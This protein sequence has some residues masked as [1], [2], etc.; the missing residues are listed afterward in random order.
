MSSQPW[1][2]QIIQASAAAILAILPSSQ[3]SV[4]AD[5]ARVP[6]AA[7]VPL[8]WRLLDDDARPFAQPLDNAEYL[9]PAG[10]E[11]PASA[12][13]GRLRIAFP[14]ADGSLVRIKDDF[15]VLGDPKWRIAALPPVEF[16]FVFAGRHLVPARR[17]SIAGEHPYW[18]WLFAPGL[19]SRVSRRDGWI[20]A[21][22]PFALMERNANCVH[23]G[24]MALRFPETG[25]T[26]RAVWQVSAETCAYLKFDAWG[27][28]AA[29]FVAAPVGDA[30]SLRRAFE[31][32]QRGRL[33]VRPIADLAAHGADPALFGHPED[34][35][36]SDMTAFG[37]VLDGVHY[38]GG[39]AT[40]TG[41][42]PFCDV[43]P[44]PSYSL[45]KS[46]FAGLALARL[47]A[48]YPG[49]AATPIAEL[50]PECRESGWDDV[51]IRD[52]IDMATGRFDAAG[53][54]ADEDAAIDSPLFLAEDHA[55]RVR[56]ACNRYARRVP[57]GTVFAYHT[58][59]TYLAV[60]AMSELLRRRAGRDKDLYRDRIVADLWRPLRLSALTYETRRSRDEVA[61]PFGGWGLLFQRDDVARLGPWLAQGGGR[62]G[63]APLLDPGLLA[64]A[65]QKDEAGHPAGSPG[66]AYRGGFWS[67]DV[68]PYVGCNHELRV[69][70][71]VGFGGI[72]VALFPNGVT[73]YH[74]A[75]GGSERW[76]HA[77]RGADRIRT[78][79]PGGNPPAAGRSNG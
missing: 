65:L 42:Y 24:I 78:L 26:G 56:Y 68:A 48:L 38:V 20:R 51:S 58:S 30:A 62:I 13:Q 1:P 57:P 71:M 61:Q 54:R 47:E 27:R 46:L 67:L 29:D 3:A 77:I 70:F 31:A 17:G 16:E 25:G 11:A 34:V 18:E 23:Y 74:F 15:G 53:P 64:A 9:L 52:A 6:D 35:A 63:R 45:A 41:A 32:E 76:A 39:C 79:C 5:E 2:Q 12:L 4:R 40:R 21:V 59:D 22:V 19:A 28:A 75:D 37:V 50:V 7:A 72:V 44:L 60:T 55:T 43:L 69:P 10:G 33:P 14:D 73:Y 49:A 66:L 36:P 8:A